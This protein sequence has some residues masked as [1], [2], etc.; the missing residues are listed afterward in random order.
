METGHCPLTGQHH[1][2]VQHL[3]QWQFHLGLV[4]LLAADRR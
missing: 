1:A 2:G 3:A 4:S